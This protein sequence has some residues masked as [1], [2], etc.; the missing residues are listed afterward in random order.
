MYESNDKKKKRGIFSTLIGAV[1]VEMHSGI[2]GT[3]NQGIAGTE[4]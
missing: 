2:A 4:V 3:T 1:V